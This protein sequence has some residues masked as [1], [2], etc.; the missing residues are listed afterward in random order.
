MRCGRPSTIHTVP[1]ATRR[2]NRCP[3]YAA[4]CPGYESSPGKKNRTAGSAANAATNVS[5]TRSRAAGVARAT[6]G[7]VRA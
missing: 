7:G 2:S 5:S 4:A 6:G 3:A 1:R